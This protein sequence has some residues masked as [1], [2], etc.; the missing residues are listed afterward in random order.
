MELLTRT[1]AIV[2][3]DG[4]LDI[5]TAPDLAQRLAPVART[6]SDLVLDLAAVRFCDCAGLNT[7]LRL[8]R[9]ACASGGSL[10]LAAPTA[11][12]R[13]LIMLVQLDEVLPLAASVDEAVSALGTDPAI[14]PTVPHAVA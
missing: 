3:L 14:M 8:R 13:R 4:E 6:G 10:H 7:F 12:V 1:L 5:V 2:V 9:L 11:V